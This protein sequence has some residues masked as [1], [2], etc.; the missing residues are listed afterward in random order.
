MKTS[1]VVLALAPTF[2]AAALAAA[3]VPLSVHVTAS[4]EVP[5]VDSANR[6]SVEKALEEKIR[7]AHEARKAAEKEIKAQHGKKKESWPAEQQEAFQALDDG[8]AQAEA[9]LAYLYLDPKGLAD[10]A[11][12]IRES[13]AG[14][15]LVSVKEY[16][17]HVDDPQQADIVVEVVGR[18]SS[19]S[20]Y[21]LIRDDQYYVAFKIKGGP[22][23]DASR[24]AKV[25]AKYTGSGFGH[26]SVKLHTWSADEPWITLE[27]FQNAR[28]A[29]VGNAAAA[30]LNDF[31]KD[32]YV[33]LK[34]K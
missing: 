28:W 6:K 10:S 4:T 29:N 27:A 26:R 2:L 9:A 30:I 23:F 22:N 16:A 17:K 32:N 11:Q 12:D 7:A 20:R 13:L 19:K 21:D 31:M 1:N 5:K 14:K 25:P 8:V 3:Q 24:L 15:G 34:A 18:R 33:A